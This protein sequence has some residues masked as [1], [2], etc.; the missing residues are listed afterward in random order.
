MIQTWLEDVRRKS[1]VRPRE[2]E[3]VRRQRLNRDLRIELQNEK[4]P[5][6][7]NSLSAVLS[8]PVA[9]DALLD[10]LKKHG[11]VSKP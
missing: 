1:A 9:L 5:L 8:S 7:S 11:F 10:L 2:K 6:T 3:A 4:G